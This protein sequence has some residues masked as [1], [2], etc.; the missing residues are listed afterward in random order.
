MMLSLP[1]SKVLNMCAVPGGK[2]IHMLILMRD[3]GLL[4]ANDISRKRLK[5]LISNLY[6]MEHHHK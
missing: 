1:Y 5:S 6:R 4:V 3:K 2:S